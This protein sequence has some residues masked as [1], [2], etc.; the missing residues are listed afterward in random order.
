MNQT[1]NCILTLNIVLRQFNC[2]PL[3]GELPSSQRQQKRIDRLVYVLFMGKTIMNCSENIYFSIL[4]F[5]HTTNITIQDKIQWDIANLQI[6]TLSTLQL[7]AILE[8]I[9]QGP[10]CCNNMLVTEQFAYSPY[11]KS[12]RNVKKMGEPLV[13]WPFSHNR[14]KSSTWEW[15]LA[16]LEGRGYKSGKKTALNHP[17]NAHKTIRFPQAILSL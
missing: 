13:S 15:G 5:Y 4:V 14:S 7:D 3:N 2:L 9:F 17:L 11:L 1:I 10:V 6:V 8:Q 12:H 16:L